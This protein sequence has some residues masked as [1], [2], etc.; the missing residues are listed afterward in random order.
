MTFIVSL[1]FGVLIVKM[2][3]GFAYLQ[4]VGRKFQDHIFY[5]C[6]I[7][8]HGPLRT[9]TKLLYIKMYIDGNHLI[10]VQHKTSG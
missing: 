2:T 4:Y 6:V 8:K 10:K 5:I 1:S 7:E 3:L 9:D